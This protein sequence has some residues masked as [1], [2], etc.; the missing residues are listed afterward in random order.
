ML[1]GGAMLLVSSCGLVMFVAVFSAAARGPVAIEAAGISDALPTHSVEIE[2]T[3]SGLRVAATN[4]TLSEFSKRLAELST[5]GIDLP[6]AVLRV[7]K[8][9]DLSSL[10]G[11][12]AELKKAGF[13]QVFVAL[14]EEP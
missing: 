14:E 9:V 1:L 5:V 11:G 12:L 13:Q 4:E 3:P 2:A 8:G 6:A 7:R 10:K